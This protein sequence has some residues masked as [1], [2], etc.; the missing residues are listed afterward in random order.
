MENWLILLPDILV[1]LIIITLAL[2]IK[3]KKQLGKYSRKASPISPISPIFLL[4]LGILYVPTFIVNIYCLIT[5][6]PYLKTWRLRTSYIS[7]AIVLIF[8]I[9]RRLKN[10]R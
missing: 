9:F 4:S 8:I 1:I 5:S 6:N 3:K 2:D 7:V 10:R